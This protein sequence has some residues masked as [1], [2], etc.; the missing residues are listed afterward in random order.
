MSLFPASSPGKGFVTFG[1]RGMHSSDPRVQ[2]MGA[3]V[4]N[5]WYQFGNPGR[6]GGSDGQWTDL[7]VPPGLPSFAK[8]TDR[9]T[10]EGLAYL[11]RDEEVVPAD[12]RGRRKGA[13][14]G[15]LAEHVH[16]HEPSDSDRI[17]GDLGNRVA[18]RVGVLA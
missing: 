4:L 17:I 10:R 18:L 2:H 7:R 1:F 11:H 3:K 15:K 12:E 5:T 6:S 14:I 8:G 13:I 16:F 9:I